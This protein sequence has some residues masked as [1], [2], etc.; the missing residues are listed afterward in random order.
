MQRLLLL[1]VATLLAFGANTPTRSAGPDSN[2][3]IQVGTIPL[4]GVEGRVDH[5]GLDSTRKRCSSPL[6]ETILL[7][8]STFAL[9][10]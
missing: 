4:D 1:I 10:E 5:F 9:A 8:W 2:L 3:L 7:K 6:S